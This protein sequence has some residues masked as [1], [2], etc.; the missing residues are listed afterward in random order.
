M[1]FY[2]F[3][4]DTIPQVPLLVLSYLLHTYGIG[5]VIQQNYFIYRDDVLRP[6]RDV[7]MDG[8]DGALIENSSNKKETE[9]LNYI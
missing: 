1:I 5:T 7:R 6:L 8:A 4:R 3:P 9:T 2:Y